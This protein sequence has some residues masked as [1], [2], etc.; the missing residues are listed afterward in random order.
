MKAF[1]RYILLFL[2]IASRSYAEPIATHVAKSNKF[3]IKEESK[4]KH[5]LVNQIKTPKYFLIFSGLGI[6]P[7]EKISIKVEERDFKGN[8]DFIYKEYL[9]KY[10]TDAE[11]LSI[12]SKLTQYF[13]DHDYLLPEVIINNESLKKG[14]LDIKVRL[15][16][17]NNVIIMGESNNLIQD[18]AKK[19][20]ETKPTT[21]KKT[22]K[23]IALMNKIPG[24]KVMYRLREDVL[25]ETSRES[26]LVDLVLT[27]NKDKGEAF[28]NL[29]NYGVNDL[30]K[31][32]AMVNAQIYSQFTESD[33]LSFIGFTTN[34]PDRLYDVGVRYGMAINSLGT[35]AYFSISHGEDNPTKNASVEAKNSEQNSLSFVVTHPLY[36]T[37]SQDLQI[38]V[39]THYKTLTNYGLLDSLT[40]AET[41]HS[42]Y[43]SG[44][45]GLE[46][47]FK[48]KLTGNNV[49][50]ADFIQGIH[51]KFKN[52]QE[53]TNVASQHFNMLKLNIYREQSLINNFSVFAHLSANYSDSDLPDQELFVLGGRV[54]GRGYPFC[55][56]DGNRMLGLALEARYSKN[57]EHKLI[58]Q[59]QPY[60]FFDTGYVG[61]QPSNTNITNLSSAG[62]GVR[63][64]L[65][66]D[67]DIS[68]EIAVPFRRSYNV[69]G[70]EEKAETRLNMFINKVFKF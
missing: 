43:W 34:H 37:A 21:V 23:Y 62:T 44:N 41:E 17:L 60:I 31:A 61:K 9:G 27:T 28:T 33:S 48:D 18:Y 57:I 70:T 8:F 7:I 64:K 13:I 66:N 58:E 29:D 52:Y 53:P 45:L 24:F 36:L 49:I 11:L 51:G 42:N 12:S 68:T 40:A 4:K 5:G 50:Q 69:D 63:F 65:A 1:S 39:G 46:Y 2:F 10:L 25:D 15:N 6:F 22:Q 38:E 20:L 55:T 35:R 3:H 56:I 47:L 19:I 14:I 30:G 16:S 26:S 67:V 54:I 59:L 32:Q